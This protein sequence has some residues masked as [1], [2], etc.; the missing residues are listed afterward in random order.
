MRC[1]IGLDWLLQRLSCRSCND[2][3]EESGRKWLIVLH[4]GMGDIV[5]ILSVIQRL[6]PQK[7]VLLV[8]KKHS[9]VSY[10]LPDYE[11]VE[12]TWRLSYLRKIRRKLRNL[13]LRG[14]FFYGTWEIYWLNR[15]IGS[16]FG[17][18]YV[19]RFDKVW[20]SGEVVK[21]DF[22]SIWE[23][24][25]R[26]VDELILGNPGLAKSVPSLELGN[27]SFEKTIV[28]ALT[29]TSAWPMGV[30]MPDVIT[31]LVN[32]LL[33]RTDWSM[34][35]VG[36]DS[37][38]S[39]LHCIDALFSEFPDRL[40]NLIGITT[41]PELCEILKSS[42]AVI[43]NDNGISHLVRF[44]G[45]PNTVAYTFSDAKDYLWGANSRVIQERRFRCMPCVK[46]EVMSPKDNVAPLCLHNFRCRET[47]DA[48]NLVADFIS[49]LSG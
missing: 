32:E 49:E 28:L 2:K 12:Y 29:K 15:I 47:I 36:S 30:L 22:V 45:L 6:D 44:F 33:R 1:L 41:F 21:V 42:D 25:S 5:M 20:V 16:R 39:Q 11:F 14:L 24:H 18:G 31:D 13:R 38:R 4:G 19:C 17:D 43:C 3:L 9:Y 48:R 8:P 27:S 10:L 23:R 40:T 34:V 26:L 35:F 46:S 37:E 7:L